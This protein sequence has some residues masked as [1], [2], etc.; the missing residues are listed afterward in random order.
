MVVD[1]GNPELNDKDGEEPVQVIRKVTPAVLASFPPLK[2][3]QQ[4][5]LVRLL[6]YPKSEPLIDIR[7]YITSDDFNGFSK[8]GITLNKEQVEILQNEI[9]NMLEQM[10][11]YGG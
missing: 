8:K 2:R 7:E 3:G 9:P 1:K 10:E 4:K 11:E 6:Q 5:F